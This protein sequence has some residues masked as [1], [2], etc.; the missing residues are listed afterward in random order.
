MPAF[1]DEAMATPHSEGEARIHPQGDRHP[2]LA[3]SGDPSHDLTSMVS[4]CGAP[5]MLEPMNEGRLCSGKRW[6]P[7]AP[8]ALTGGL[9]QA[10]RRRRASPGPCPQ[11]PQGEKDMEGP[12]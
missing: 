6:A 9:L 1:T 10:Q 3:T 7:S 11:G 2:D 8:R 4:A 5:T 12:I